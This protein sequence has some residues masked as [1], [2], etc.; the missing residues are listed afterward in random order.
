[1]ILIDVKKENN[2]IQSISIKGHAMYDDYGK[3]IVCSGVSSI[4]ITTVNGLILLDQNY[5]SIVEKKDELIIVVC[6]H[7]RICDTLLLNMINLFKELVKTYP[8]N[9]QIK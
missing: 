7:D 2:Q 1:M 6:K 3:D 8:K 9:V 5:V 4:T